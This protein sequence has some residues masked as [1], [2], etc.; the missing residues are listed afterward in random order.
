MDY[1]GFMD[2]L[3]N[4]GYAEKSTK[5]APK[6]KTWYIPYHGVY[7]PSKPG[8]MRVVFDYSAEFKEVS[9]NKNLMSGPDLTNQI[10]GVP[11]RFCEEPV[12]I[13]GDIEPMF[14]QVMVP[15]GGGRSLLRFL[16]W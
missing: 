7:H 6:G 15:R 10:V 9:L 5:E 13:M 11:T 2:D 3:I 14:H 4:K 12:V 8:K 16:W 1:K